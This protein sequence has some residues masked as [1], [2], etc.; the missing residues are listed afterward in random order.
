MCRVLSVQSFHQTD[1]LT[2]RWWGRRRARTPGEQK[3]E[4]LR[5]WQND[6]RL[7]TLDKR[8]KTQYIHSVTQL[9]I[10]QV[11][12]VLAFSV[13]IFT[14]VW[15]FFSCSIKDL[16]VAIIVNISKI[17]MFCHTSAILIVKTTY[18]FCFWSI[19]TFFCSSRLCAVQ[20]A[21]LSSN[22]FRA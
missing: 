11:L 20:M 21:T 5:K 6:K 7:H 2:E 4:K 19:W 14:I 8:K 16:Q 9:T 15:S 17:S 10:T 12:V 13:D 18:M 3:N 1:W 22:H